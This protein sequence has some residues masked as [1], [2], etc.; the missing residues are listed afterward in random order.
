MAGTKVKLNLPG[1]KALRT[2]SEARAE[3]ERR[4]Q[5]V[6]AAAGPGYVVMPIQEPR[7][8]AI[9]MVT[10]EPGNFAARAREARDHR[11]LGALDAGRG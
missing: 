7:N 4:A 8:R 9:A 10:T 2:S 1:F 3:I 6:A 5:A 11:L